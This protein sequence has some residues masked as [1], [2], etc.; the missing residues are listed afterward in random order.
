MSVDDTPRLKLGQLVDGQELD[1]MTINDALIGLDAFTDIC[2]K[3]QFTNTP[4]PSPAD[5]DMYL[6]GG[7]PTGAWSG[8][9]Y[10]LAYCLDGGWRFFA[11]FDG[12][13]AFVSGSNGF[14]VYIGGQW[15]DAN[16]LIGASEVAIASAATCDLGAAGSLC[17]AVTGTTAITGFGTGTNLL[18]FVRFAGALALTHNAASLILPG[19]AAIVTAAGDTACFTSDGGGNWR[20]RHYQRANGQPVATALDVA[21]LTASGGIVA[22]GVSQFDSSVGIR[23]APGNAGLV[24]KGSANGSDNVLVIQNTSGIA[25]GIFVDRDV[26]SGENASSVGVRIR[27]DSTTSRSIN[28]AGTINASG[29][30]IA[31]YYTKAA[32]CGLIGKGCLAGIDADGLVTDKWDSAKSFAFKSTAPNLCGGDVW[33]SEAALGMAEPV[34]PVKP[35]APAEP[36]DPPSAHDAAQ[37]RY[38]ADRAAFDAALEAARRKVDRMA[39]AGKIPAVL[40]GSFA[41]GD[42]VIPARDGVHIKAIAVAPDSVSL[43]HLIVKVGT[44]LV[45]MPTQSQFRALLGPDVA[46]DPAWNAIVRV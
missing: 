33:G 23:S 8:Y 40:S 6:L 11:P 14:L 24:I 2:L 35:D 39:C 45:A 44:V 22:G 18:R 9:A 34:V 25:V 16:A 38:L 37:A 19:G 42:L 32:D 43:R 26:L 41:A 28:A 12:L 36:Q 17:V 4:P 1:A 20:C 3:G 29:A 31:E 7:G 5:G 30:D 15:I 21:S 27:K 10:K 46:L 13:R